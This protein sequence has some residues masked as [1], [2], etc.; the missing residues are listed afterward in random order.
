MPQKRGRGTGFQRLT[1]AEKRE[2]R[3]VNATQGQQQC[4]KDTA[5]AHVDSVGTT[6]AVEAE[7]TALFGADSPV[8]QCDA[9]DRYCAECTVLFKDADALADYT[10]MKHAIYIGSM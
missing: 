1:K 8:Q 5:M 9:A 10:I 4:L 2:L 6:A 7:W 3:S